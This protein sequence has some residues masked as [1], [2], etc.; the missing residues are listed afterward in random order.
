[1]LQLLHSKQKCTTQHNFMSYPKRGCRQNYDLQDSWLC[2]RGELLIQN[3]R[4]VG[5]APNQH[6]IFV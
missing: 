6:A 4:F 5:F 1:M 3:I 2:P